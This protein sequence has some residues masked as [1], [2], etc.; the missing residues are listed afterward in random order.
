MLNPIFFF[1]FSQKMSSKGT[2]NI[3]EPIPPGHK[4]QRNSE[5]KIFFFFSWINNFE[6]NYFSGGSFYSPSSSKPPA[7]GGRSPQ[8]SFDS[9]GDV[10]QIGLNF[11]R[12]NGA[13][14]PF[15]TL[16]TKDRMPQQNQNKDLN[17]ACNLTGIGSTTTAIP[18]TGIA[19]VGSCYTPF[20]VEQPMIKQKES[21]TQIL[22]RKTSDPV[23]IS[24]D[25]SEHFFGIKKKN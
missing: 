15:K 25:E 11:M 12:F 2:P 23:R 16:L 8:S 13:Y 18:S 1:W 17:V 9:N 19:R 3:L 5:S 21:W 20:N 22:P 4:S 14:A 24:I 10:G 6:F 7:L